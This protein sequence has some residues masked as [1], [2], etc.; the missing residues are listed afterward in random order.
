METM[1]TINCPKCNTPVNVE[2]AIYSRLQAEFARKD[3]QREAEIAEQQ[4]ILKEAK[5]AL[6]KEKNSIELEVQK[7]LNEERSK[8]ERDLRK[9]LKKELEEENSQ[10]TKELKAQL[11]AAQ[12]IEITL[13]AESDAE[14][15]RAKRQ[16][17]SER[18]AMQAEMRAETRKQQAQLAEENLEQTK[19]LKAEAKRAAEEDVQLLL[20]DKEHQLKIAKEQIEQAQKKIQQ[21]A[22]QAQGEVQELLIEKILAEYFRYD[23]IEEIKKGDRGADCVLRVLSRT[24]VE[25]GSILIE[26]KRTNTFGKDWIDK[27]KEDGI[28]AKASILLIVTDAFPKDINEFGQKEEVWICSIKN[29]VWIIEVLREQIIKVYQEKSKYTNQLDKKDMLYDYFGSDEFLAHIKIILKSYSIQQELINKERRAMEKLWKAR[30]NSLKKGALSI[31]SFRGS[32]ENIMGEEFSIIE[33]E[34][35]ADNLLED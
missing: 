3:D 5:D 16:L 6:E 4:W 15:E 13:K 35:A 24:G 19:L 12:Q 8:L 1:N 14:K 7:K 9:D 17:Q 27:I 21:G 23:K 26:S 11:A 28:K 34:E 2:G 22:T 10:E 18:E 25:M 29:F 30:E 33:L 20:A 32:V 31:Q